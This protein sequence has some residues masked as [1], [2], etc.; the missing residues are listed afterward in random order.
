ME[1]GH[2]LFAIVAIGFSWLAFYQIYVPLTKQN[3]K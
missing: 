3:R 1:L 2:V